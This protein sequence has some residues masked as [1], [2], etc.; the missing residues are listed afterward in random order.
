MTPAG[1]RGGNPPSREHPIS[2]G[3]AGG[4]HPGGGLRPGQVT[5]PRGGS[6]T[7][8]LPSPPPA[9]GTAPGGTASPPP[10]AA[11]GAG[12]GRGRPR[13]EAE[14]GG[15]RREQPRSARGAAPLSA[16]SVPPSPSSPSG[17][18]SRGSGGASAGR[19]RSRAALLGVWEPTSPSRRVAVRGRCGVFKPSPSL[20]VP[21]RGDGYLSHLEPGLG[22]WGT[23]RLRAEMQQF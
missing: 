2:G 17:S 6:A 20:F 3:S 23:P 5:P 7:S 16:G 1:G 4:R 22:T 14:L 15:S 19:W 12:S 13:R 8:R 10:G 11:P 21:A 9:P 18:R